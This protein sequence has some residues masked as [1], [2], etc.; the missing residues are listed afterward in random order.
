MKFNIP[1]RTLRDWMRRLNIK[2]VF[3][4]TQTNGKPDG[5]P[6]ASSDGDD[7]CSVTSSGSSNNEHIEKTLEQNLKDIIHEEKQEQEVI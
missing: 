1:A 3:T 5:T 4:H 7:A 2:S 6:R